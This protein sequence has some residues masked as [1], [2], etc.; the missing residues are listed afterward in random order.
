VQ[1]FV[2]DDRTALA[3]IQDVLD[4]VGGW[5]LPNRDGAFEVGRFE[6]PMATPA[7]RFDVDTQVIADTLERV[8]SE[9]PAWRINLEYAPV[10]LVQ[11][12]DQLAGA[13]SAAE[14]TL[15]GNEFRSVTV[16]NAA[17]KTKHLA[18]PELTIRTSLRFA[19]DAEGEADRLLG[20]YSTE[21]DRYRAALTLADAWSA[22]PGFSITLKHDRLGLAGGKPFNVIGRVDE[23]AKETV[24]FDLWG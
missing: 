10:F 15:V 12:E 16:E 4:S 6:A 20:L 24:T 9:I 5:I 2:D 18:A 21:R 17:V 3:A 19:A 1:Y 8:D 22:E 13:V 7:L 23:Y 14:R 11:G